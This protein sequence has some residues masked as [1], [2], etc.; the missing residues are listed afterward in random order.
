MAWISG[1]WVRNSKES[2]EFG[3][4]R[5]FLGCEARETGHSGAAGQCSARKALQIRR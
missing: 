1:A 3:D 5:R 2:R 4:L